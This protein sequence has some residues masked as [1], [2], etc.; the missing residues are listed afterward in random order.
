MASTSIACVERTFSAVPAGTVTAL[1]AGLGAGW[2]PRRGGAAAGF[3]GGGGGGAGFRAE[4][5]T[6]RT[7][8]NR[9]SETCPPS[10][11][12]RT[13]LL[14]PPM[15]MPSTALPDRK[16]TRSAESDTPTVRT[17]SAVVHA[18]LRMFMSHSC[19][20]TIGSA[21]ETCKSMMR[22]N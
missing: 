5:S 8:S 13:D 18:A 17:S 14:S 9:A 12:T 16:R 21:A 4:N 19:Y 2:V 3:A 1:G 6:A 20:L 15:K 7:S 11:N 22:S 10:R